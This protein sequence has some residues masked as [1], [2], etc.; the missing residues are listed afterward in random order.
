MTI[1]I[2]NNK[3]S[4]GGMVV[5]DVGITYTK[6]YGMSFDSSINRQVIEMGNITN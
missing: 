2:Y 5:Y 6:Q 3:P 4:L 1:I